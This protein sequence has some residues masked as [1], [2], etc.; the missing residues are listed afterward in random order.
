MIL[1]GQIC[2]IQYNCGKQCKNNSI[3]IFGESTGWEGCGKYF[4]SERDRIHFHL[5]EC[6]F[7]TVQQNVFCA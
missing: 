1:I 7:Q 2:K 4:T 3:I 6:I 5:V